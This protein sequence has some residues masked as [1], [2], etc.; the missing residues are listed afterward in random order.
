MLC[1]Q[2]GLAFNENLLR[3]G[4][5]TPPS[6]RYG[7]PSGIMKH[8]R[9]STGSMDG[10]LEHG[11]DPQVRHLLLSYI[12]ALGH[13][14]LAEMGYDSGELSRALKALP[15]NSGKSA[16]SWDQLMKPD[17]SRAERLILVLTEAR[18]E[19]NPGQALKQ[20]GRLLTNRN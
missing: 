6:G 7:D 19:R 14:L 10:W 20:L 3:Y 9:P 15:P 18:R 11:K 12:D 4:E 1:D 17:K 5:R 16:V 2:L 13:D 8:D